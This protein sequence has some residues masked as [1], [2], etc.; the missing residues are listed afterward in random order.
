MI[1]LAHTALVCVAAIGGLLI[2]RNM[3]QQARAAQHEGT[4]SV[5][6]AARDTAL[7]LAERYAAQPVM[8]RMDEQERAMRVLDTDM[9]ATLKEITRRLDEIRAPGNEGALSSATGGAPVRRGRF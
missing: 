5:A 3:L 4:L 9:R 2:V 8:Q 7:A 6:T 1:A